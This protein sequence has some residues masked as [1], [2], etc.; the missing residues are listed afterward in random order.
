MSYVNLKKLSAHVAKEYKKGH[1]VLGTLEDGFIIATGTVMTWFSQEH[2]PNTVKA[3]I[4]EYAGFIPTKGSGLISISK[5]EEV[6][7]LEEDGGKYKVLKQLVEMDL[8]SMVKYFET[9]LVLSNMSVLQNS[10]DLS[11]TL[12]NPDVL[13]IVEP[14]LVD[15]EVEGDP[16]GP[17]ATSNLTGLFYSNSTTKVLLMPIRS[18]NVI[19]EKVLDV[20]TIVDMADLVAASK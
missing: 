4:A 9:P 12:M 11:F 15:Y 10:K 8:T 14:A 5:G 13:K 20:L 18:K 2:T 7:Y 16:V 6:E 17:V 3:I 19:V 1:V